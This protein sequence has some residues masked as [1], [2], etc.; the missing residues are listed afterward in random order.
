MCD[1]IKFDELKK[2]CKQMEKALCC[3]NTD[4]IESNKLFINGK[5]YNIK[6]D[7]KI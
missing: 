3:N 4:R 7:S 1:D 5:Y 2:L 6:N